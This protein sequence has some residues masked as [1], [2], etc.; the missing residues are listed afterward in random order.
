MQ[1]KE[2][3]NTKQLYKEAM[4]AQIREIDI[5]IKMLLD[6]AEKAGTDAKQEYLIQIQHLRSQQQEV[7]QELNRLVNSSDSAWEDLR[8]GVDNAWNDLKSAFDR[9]K[10]NFQ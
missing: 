10:A 3:E 7:I 4:E 9:A 5:G 6:K 2:L 1:T 8:S